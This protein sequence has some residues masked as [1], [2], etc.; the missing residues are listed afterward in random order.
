MLAVEPDPVPDRGMK[1]FWWFAP[2]T[3]D[4]LAGL[5]DS[6]LCC[7]VSLCG[8]LSG[9]VYIYLF[10]FSMVC[11]GSVVLLPG[12]WDVCMVSG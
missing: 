8:T 3:W 11:L 2:R 12:I 4:E 7:E 6:G 1:L 10:L 9:T 5:C